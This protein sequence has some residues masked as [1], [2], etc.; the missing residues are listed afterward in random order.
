MDRNHLEQFNGKCSILVSEETYNRRMDGKP[1][2]GYP[3]DT[4]DSKGSMYV[5]TSNDIDK[6]LKD[7][8]GDISKLE[9]SLGL[10]EGHFG[11]GPV[12]R[13]DI[14]NPEEYGLRIANGKEAGANE[15]FNTKADE[16]G[17]LPKIEHTTT[18]DGRWAVDTNKT[19]PGELAKLNGQYIDQ[20]GTY[21]PP[22][23][24]GYDGKT[25]GGM[26]EAVIDRVPNN[27]ENISYT[28]IDGFKHG[29]NSDLKAT[30][31]ND[32]YYN[33]DSLSQI[34]SQNVAAVTGG[35][36]NAPNIAEADNK[37]NFTSDTVCGKVDTD[38]TGGFY[39][40]KLPSDE[41]SPLNNSLNVS[42]NNL[43]M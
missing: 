43:G 40:A 21:H 30:K 17:N 18:S 28:K 12:V 15:Y 22:N 19:D 33:S 2:I 41:K 42:N 29:E 34:N 35:G 38:K 10:P 20:N 26:S 27:A 6:A 13:V 32:G 1:Y 8:N 11:D 39:D 7:C 36:A 16:N 24:A 3:P 14:N 5:S 31:L 37:G 9:S 4:N 23:V 25:S